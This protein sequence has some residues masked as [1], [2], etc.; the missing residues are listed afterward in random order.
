MNIIRTMQMKLII[1]QFEF[2]VKQKYTKNP[3]AVSKKK[4]TDDF[5]LGKCPECESEDV[6]RVWNIGATDVAVGLL[7]NSKTDFAKGPTY[8]PSTF[9]KYKGTKI[10]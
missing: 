5:E 2:L 3:I 6:K 1:L 4:I 9:G 8:H 7:G 10:K